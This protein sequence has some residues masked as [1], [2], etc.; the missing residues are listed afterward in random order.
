MRLKVANAYRK[1]EIEILWL[2]GGYAV[3]RQE[4][5]EEI[6]DTLDEAA[7]K[8]GWGLE[9]D[10]E[11]VKAWSKGYELPADEDQKWPE[12]FLVKDEQ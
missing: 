12:I 8:A 4:G 3:L 2:A 9:Q 10:P 11:L 7:T 6:F 5:K 1:G